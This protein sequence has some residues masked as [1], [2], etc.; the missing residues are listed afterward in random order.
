M[1][2]PYQRLVGYTDAR[3]HS[4]L[5]SFCK[6]NKT[7]KLL[8]NKENYFLPSRFPFRELWNASQQT[9]GRPNSAYLFSFVS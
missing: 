3:H 1:I 4:K 5:S 9:V 2:W 6:T 7:V 8:Q